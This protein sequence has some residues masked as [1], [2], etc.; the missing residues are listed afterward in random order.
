MPTIYVGDTESLPE[1]VKQDVYPTKDI[2]L[3]KEALYL[4]AST[5]SKQILDIGAGDGRWGE[6]AKE[7]CP[8]SH[9]T[10][11]DIREL[12]KP[13]AFDLWH[14]DFDF[15]LP[16]LTNTT[17]NEKS[18]D[19]VVG[20]PP[21]YCVTQIIKNVWPLMTDDSTMIMLLKLEFMTSQNRYKY[22]WPDFSPV[23]VAPVVK[24]VE[25]TGPGNPNEVAIFVWKKL[26][27]QNMA[28]PCNWKTRLL[29]HEKEIRE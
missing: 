26:D 9:L 1:R 18:F 29:W 7:T 11:V 21:F 25:F 19:L 12:P 22:L 4:Y 15:S 3:I 2:G 24:R 23:E 10:G 14:D 5:T 28:I 13:K 27:G 17:F 6:L 20:N 8:K 16:L